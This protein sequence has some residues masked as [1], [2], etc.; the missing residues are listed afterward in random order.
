MI[1]LNI[2]LF[3][4]LAFIVVF[5]SIKM[6]ILV[7]DVSKFNKRKGFIFAGILLAGITSLP[8]FVTS[9]TAVK[10]GNPYLAVGDIFGSNAFNI[11]IMC[12]VDFVFLNY[13]MFNN[14][15]K[16]YYVEYLILII[17]YIV[18]L[19]FVIIDT[20]LS[21]FKIGIPTLFFIGGYLFYIK[22]ISKNN[23][24]ENDNTLDQ[25]NKN[26]I[27]KIIF[28]ASLLIIC[29][30]FLTKIVNDFSI[31]YPTISSSVFGAI[32]LG[33][34]TSLPEVITFITLV[35]L[36][37][38]DMAV[39]DILGSNIFNCFILGINDFIVKNNSIYLYTDFEGLGL[40]MVSIVITI[41]NFFQLLRKKV[42]NKIL[43]LFPTILVIFIYI[44]FWIRG[45]A[46]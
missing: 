11:F 21:L 38:F 14:V 3:F 27:L 24:G 30:I 26:R 43:Y 4:F 2:V 39:T 42:N 15:F 46:K 17:S 19:F 18:M 5:T 13:F 33:I 34:T 16:K 32:C 23:N 25:R 9:I 8:E 7:N 40:L 6:S 12:F 36:K 10:M 28:Y 31:K 41:I 44:Y 1:S 45:F 35:K 37:S 22:K 20:D 29:S